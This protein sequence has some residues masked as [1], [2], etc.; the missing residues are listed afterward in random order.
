M[1]ANA[2]PAVMSVAEYLES[3]RHSAIKHEHV[4]G[5]VYAVAGGT[6]A[7]G[8]IA[9]NVTIALGNHLRGGPCRVYN[10][11]VKVQLTDCCILRGRRLAR[12]A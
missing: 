6:R 4:D 10:S 8:V 5:H 9:V 11:D 7:H 3:E 1:P 12:G 2:N